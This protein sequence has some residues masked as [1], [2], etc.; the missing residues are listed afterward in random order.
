MPKKLT[1]RRA[2]EY[3]LPALMLAFLLFYTYAYFF[4][5]PFLGFGFNNTDGMVETVWVER[6]SS[7]SLQPRD[8]LLR[9]DSLDWETF[10]RDHRLPLL[11]DADPGDV[12]EIRVQ[13]REQETTILWRLPGPNAVELF[14]RLGALWLL[15]IFWFAGTATFFLVRPRSNQ[16]RL[17]IA[18]YY[19]MA[20][21]LVVGWMS[22]G[23]VWY[24]RI[25]APLLS[26]FI[27]PVYLHL[28]WEFP[29]P[30]GQIPTGLVWA[31]YLSAGIL[32]GMEI[33][34][35]TPRLAYVIGVLLA[36]VGGVV[37]L[38]LHAILQPDM[39]RDLKVLA[40]AVLL[41][42]FSG[43]LL[44]TQAYTF[45]ALTIGIVWTALLS[46]TAI[47]GAYFY[48][49]YRRQLGGLELR[50]NRIISLYLFS[51][52]L[53]TFAAIVV[54]FINSK[55]TDQDI[56]IA[57]EG[58]GLVLTGLVAAIIFPGFQRLIERRILGIPIAQ[59]HLL[60]AYAAKITTSLDSENLVTL[61]RD[62]IL[63]SLLVRQSA[64]LYINEDNPI[65]SLYI[66]GITEGEKP[67]KSDIPVLMKQSG[68]YQP[69]GLDNGFD[70]PLK[71][72]RLVLLLE[73]G[74]DLIGMWL[75]GRRDPDDYYTQSEIT[76]LQ[77]IANQT[78]I[79][80]IN[81]AHTKLLHTLY[82]AD[83]ERQDNKRAAL[84]RGLHDEVLNQLA[85]LFIRQPVSSEAVSFEESEV[86][87]T[88]YLRQ[89]ISDLRPAMLNYG[90]QPAID[91]LVDGLSQRGTDHP[92]FEIGLEPSFL[93][94]DPTIEQHVFHIVQQACE[95]AV[96]H[97]HAHNVQVNGIL[98]PGNIHLTVVDDGVG[99][100][101]PSSQDLGL[102]LKQE[103]YGLVGMYERAAIIGAELKIHSQLGWGTSVEVVWPKNGQ[104]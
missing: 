72:V 84:A 18:F 51:L 52:L 19:L 46:L 89:V 88:N 74:G 6:T 5:M 76:V 43:I 54:W 85:A 11:E 68:I 21:W 91:E 41:A 59:T 66:Y 32:A 103:H 30:L 47:P 50:A 57:L 14:D 37:L 56:Q 71:W 53:I 48:V 3:C 94:F 45:M 80:L 86:L 42:L 82:Q 55:I 102:L 58:A 62:E 34:Q 28:N 40:V 73:A 87:I 96:R 33:F 101:A 63:P 15:F 2:L 26:W 17:L 10:I 69:L 93:R 36:L 70:N 64:L 77:I 31:A 49:I 35:L 20:A 8:R 44:S 25:L 22:F 67:K 100:P 98:K 38:V 104:V 78:A 92:N 12:V 7:Q 24:S 16:R 90:L 13:R 95:N 65:N 1:F 60:E 4:K 29:K 9:V 81:I 83:I 61:L 79:A 27:L 99:F 97:A 39:R 75:L 23:G